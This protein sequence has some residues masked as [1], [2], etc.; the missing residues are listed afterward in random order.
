M[1]LHPEREMAA[2]AQSHHHTIRRPRAGLQHG[3]HRAGVN[4]QRVVARGLEGV[5]EPREGS[6]AIMVH[7]RGLP[8]HWLVPHDR[9][10][11]RAAQ[12]LV[13]KA[14]AEDW[15]TPAQLSYR[16]HRDPRVLRPARTGRDDKRVV[17]TQLLD[18]DGVVAE[19]LW[20]STQ[21][22]QV[23]HQV[24]CE[25]VVVVDDR[26]PCVHVSDSACSTAANMA[27]AFSSVSSYSRAGW[28]SATTP[29]PAWM[30]ASPSAITIVRSV[31][32]MSRLPPNPT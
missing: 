22:R 25:G 28:E 19:H 27:P 18:A 16:L 12:R 24:V 9:C 30:W 3:W 6:A 15:Q 23:L 5:G 32:A 10:A 20:V 11:E 21:L 14:D 2:V 8:V 13:P 17:A 29:A 26:N 31:I 7:L 4:D 1:E